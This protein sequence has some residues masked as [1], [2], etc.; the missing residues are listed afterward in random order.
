MYT[1]ATKLEDTCLFFEKL[2][3]LYYTRP[4]IIHLYKKDFM[5]IRNIISLIL[6]HNSLVVSITN[7]LLLLLNLNFLSTKTLH[8]DTQ[9]PSQ[10]D[11][12]NE[13][14]EI[15]KEEHNF[16]QFSL[17][18]VF[19]SSINFCKTSI[20]WQHHYHHFKKEELVTCFKV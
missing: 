17:V 1:M 5:M 9:E 6:L 10:Q 3:A 14:Q 16:F 7:S 20:A 4:N 12:S 11:K 13:L 15:C 19:I 8:R 18:H 2:H